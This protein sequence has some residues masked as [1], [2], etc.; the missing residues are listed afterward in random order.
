M[1][2]LLVYIYL[3]GSVAAYVIYAPS[4]ANDW[5]ETARLYVAA[6]TWPVSAPLVIAYFLIVGVIEERR[7][8]NPG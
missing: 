7:G 5:N 3:V 2:Y 6:I 4:T 8:A 1:L